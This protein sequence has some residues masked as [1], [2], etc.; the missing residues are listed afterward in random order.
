MKKLLILIFF[1][2]NKNILG[3]YKVIGYYP[4]WSSLKEKPFLPEDIDVTK[5]SHINYA[6]ARIDLS[7]NLVLSNLEKHIQNFN[8]FFK[9]KKTNPNLKVLISI[10]ITETDQFSKVICD[11]STRTNFIKNCMNFCR[12]NN[13]DGVDFDW[14]YPKT[15]EDKQNFSI[16]LENFFKFKLSDFP[17][18][19]LTIAAPAG[20]SRIEKFDFEKIHNYLDIIN[21]MTYDLHGPWQ[22]SKDVTNHLSGLQ[23][24]EMGHPKL[25]VES[26]INHYLSKNIPSNKLVLGIPLYGRSYTCI[27]PTVTGLFSK[28]IAKGSGNPPGVHIYSSL[29][30]KI[31]PHYSKYW[32]EKAKATYF[33][34][35]KS[36]DFVSCESPESLKSKVQFLKQL[37]LAGF[38]FWAIYNNSVIEVI[39]F[40]NKEMSN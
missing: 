26:I 5:F 17:E 27:N 34:D 8:S 30:E 10:Q 9:L 1:I 38:M 37:N 28:Y 20:I 21:V 4:S 18:L 19:L 35:H 40:V 2:F 13:L 14:E 22:P 6:F 12:T 36:N 33:Y 32:D 24:N 3:Q 16:L 29:L 25:N 23:H 31:F 11:S 7:G 15:E 39:D